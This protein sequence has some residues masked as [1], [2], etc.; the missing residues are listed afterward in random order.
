MK[1]I[2][3]VAAECV[4]FI[5]TGGLADVVGTLPKTFPKEEAD[6]RV[7]IP[8]YACIKPEWKAK[9]KDVTSF[10]MDLSWRNQYVGIKTLQYEGITF[11]FIDNEFYFAGSA[12]YSTM[13][14]D[15][16]KFCY[17]SK[18]ALAICQVLDFKP[19]IIHCHD[20]QAGLLPVYLK[21]QFAANPFYRDIKTVITIHNL[22]YQ[23]M[24][25][26]DRLK[27]LSGLPN[28]V[29]TA[30]KLECYGGA[31]ML[32]GGLTYAD[33]ITT[34]SDSYAQE[35][36]MPY[37]GEKLDG[38]L[39]ARKDNLT[40]IV[41][42]IDYGI[43]NPMT[44]PMILHH[45]GVEDRK[46][47]KTANKLALQKRLGLPENP[48]I[49]TIGV[50]SRLADQKG[51]D[52][53]DYVMDDICKEDVQF[54]LL[55]SGEPR[56]ENMFRYYAGKYQERVAVTIG[57]DDSLSKMIYAGCDAIL[58]P[59]RFEPCG[60]CQLM[61]LRYGTVPVVRETGG[62]RDTVESYNEVEHTGTGFSFANYN[63][64]DMLNAIERAKKVYYENKEDWD[65]MVERGMEKDFSWDRSA[66]IYMNLY[67]KM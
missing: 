16:E 28:E 48:E 46:E 56:Y 50:I 10:I 21:T 30:D 27:D 2:L 18:A 60:L 62:L 61:A 33:A 54:I 11:Y 6:V 53:F 20:W 42:G 39:R 24:T 23:G 45:Y 59:S 17:F 41:N 32:K 35:V 40:G 8:N 15:I 52:L 31:N 47:G 12:P 66:D 44:D 65:D 22:Q 64:H 14:G 5:K 19:D 3:Y 36:Q 25:A 13:E 55:G 67:K 38:L 58:M 37:Y 9:M 26:I 1:R 57:Y 63:A 4:P 34:V 7:V 51:F 49:F 43:Y 29:F